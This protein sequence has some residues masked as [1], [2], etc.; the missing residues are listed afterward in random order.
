MCKKKKKPI[1]QSGRDL[2]QS[3]MNV[4]H[5]LPRLGFFFVSAPVRIP[6]VAKP[7]NRVQIRT[8]RRIDPVLPQRVTSFSGLVALA[9]VKLVFG[10]AAEASCRCCDLYRRSKQSMLA[11]L[12][13]TP[14]QN[15]SGTIT[16]GVANFFFSHSCKLKMFVLIS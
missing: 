4:L 8:L 16:L 7:Q 15:R 12:Q 2:C 5:L 10:N 9:D 1:C 11:R 6:S 14:P 3:R 13:S